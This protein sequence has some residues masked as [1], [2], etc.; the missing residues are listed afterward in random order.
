[1]ETP[2]LRRNRDDQAPPATNTLE[3]SIYPASV[4]TPLTLPPEISR[5]RAAQFS[6]ILT[7]FRTASRA[8]AGTAS[9][10]SAR[11]SD[12]V[13]IA[14]LNLRDMPLMSVAVSSPSS[15][16]VS[17]AWI[18]AI[19]MKSSK[20][21]MSLSVVREVS[22][23]CLGQ[24]DVFAALLSQLPPQANSLDDDGQFVRVASLLSDPAP[25][26]RRLFGRDAPFFQQRHR[27]VALRQK[28]RRRHAD[29][30][31]TNDHHLRR[32]RRW[33]EMLDWIRLG[34]RE[35]GQV[36]HP[37][38]LVDGSGYVV[39]T[40]QKPKQGQVQADRCPTRLQSICSQRSQGFELGPMTDWTSIPVPTSLARLFD[41]L[42]RVL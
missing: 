38:G 18:A 28:K 19:F 30:T 35:F 27:N 22:H 15:R 26:S 42:R 1:M 39:A 24:P 5:V 13:V 10:G 40:L 20:P 32:L 16:R 21:A 29:N 25:I 7:P 36:A 9:Q 31:A 2:C 37:C 34:E 4:H 11:M 41:L 12:G 6:T 3:A 23:T 14:P 8:S 17:R 33:A